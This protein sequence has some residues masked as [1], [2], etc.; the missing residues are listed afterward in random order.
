MMV[1]IDEWDDY[2]GERRWR[3]SREL[4]IESK[5]PNNQTRVQDRTGFV[6]HTS[7]ISNNHP[8]NI[9]TWGRRRRIG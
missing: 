5:E 2:E 4:V 8:Q 1:R 6:L 3:W 9:E 7:S